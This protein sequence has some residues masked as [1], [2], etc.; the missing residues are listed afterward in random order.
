MP[1][2]RLMKRWS[3]DGSLHSRLATLG[4]KVGYRTI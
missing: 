4:E 3:E 1:G 2:V